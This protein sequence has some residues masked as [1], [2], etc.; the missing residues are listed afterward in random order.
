MAWTDLKREG[1]GVV[2]GRDEEERFVVE[3]LRQVAA[4][5]GDA[6][7]PEIPVGH[8]VDAEEGGGFGGFGGGLGRCLVDG[9]SGFSC[10]DLRVGSVCG[11]AAV[12][13]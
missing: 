8:V 11:V 13:L 10:C 3:L 2:D 9:C 6:K 7:A 1:E 12:F 5:E 4:S